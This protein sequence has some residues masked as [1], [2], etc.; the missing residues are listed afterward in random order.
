MPQI[1]YRSSTGYQFDFL[2][3]FYWSLWWQQYSYNWAMCQQQN[4]MGYPNV[5]VP[6]SAPGNGNVEMGPSQTD[7][8]T[9]MRP[10]Q[11]SGNN[12]DT[13]RDQQQ[14][15][16]PHAWGQ[17]QFNQQWNWNLPQFGVPFQFPGTRIGQVYLRMTAGVFLY[18]SC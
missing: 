6:T 4:M 2:N 3:W 13:N 11:E 17:P 10:N 9:G 12:T 7:N 14:Q 15:Q 1:I 16:Q 18:S 8:G 5:N